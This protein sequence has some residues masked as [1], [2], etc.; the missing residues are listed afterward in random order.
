M[1]QPWWYAELRHIEETALVRLYVVGEDER[2]RLRMEPRWQP[3]TV[4][5]PWTMAE[6]H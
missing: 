2:A 6:A 4:G 3:L 5:L 1:R